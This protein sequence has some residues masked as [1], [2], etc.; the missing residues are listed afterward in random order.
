MHPTEIT[1]PGPPPNEQRRRLPTRETVAI[2]AL[3][4]FMAGF[5]FVKITTDPPEPVPVVV[6]IGEPET[7]VSDVNRRQ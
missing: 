7:V 1:P 3:A 6:D 4:G 5:G 2:A